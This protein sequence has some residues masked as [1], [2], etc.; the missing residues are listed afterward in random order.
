VITLACTGRI[1]DILLYLPKPVMVSDYVYESE[2]LQF[3]LKSLVESGLLAVVSADTQAE[4]NMVVNLAVY[5]DDGEAVTGAIG[6]S[7]NWAIATDDKK[8]LSLFGRVAPHIELVS[9]LAMVKY[10][11]EEAAPSDE[12]VRGALEELL[13]GAPYEPNSSHP[14]YAWWRNYVS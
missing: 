1:N 9:T 8:A 6:V 3:D 11:A 13:T 4:Q 5:L 2:V 10:W 14:L 7:R 12:E